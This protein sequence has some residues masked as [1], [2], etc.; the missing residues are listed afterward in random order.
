MVIEENK[1]K[2]MKGE[3]ERKGRARKKWRGII[4]QIGRAGKECKIGRQ[5]M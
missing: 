1:K 4:R 2:K 3:I 5:M